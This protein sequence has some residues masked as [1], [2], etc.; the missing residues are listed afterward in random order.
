MHSLPFKSAITTAF[1]SW[2]KQHT[3]TCQLDEPEMLP[4]IDWCQWTAGPNAGQ[5]WWA[6][7]WFS[8]RYMRPEDICIV[9]GLEIHIAQDER[10]RMA[11]KAL[12][13]G[14]DGKLIELSI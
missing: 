5:Y 14:A 7:C 2:L 13:I 12:D 3:A 4:S 1:L 11:Q 8:R 9:D 6:V 10:E